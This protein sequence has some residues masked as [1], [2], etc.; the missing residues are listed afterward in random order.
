MP[1]DTHPCSVTIED[2][3]AIITKVGNYS[4]LEEDE[5]DHHTTGWILPRI[6]GN[7]H[8]EQIFIN[9][10]SKGKG[11]IVSDGSSKEGR[12]TSAF[13][14]LPNKNIHG[15]KKVPEEPQ[16]QISYRGELGGILASICYTN[17]ICTNHN[18]SEG[19]CAMYCDNKWALS[20]AF[21]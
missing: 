15:S 14:V 11:Q 12:S 21:G 9:N 20:A 5:E 19:L 13:V 3:N 6:S 10:I 16:D 2:N 7:N 17:K 1:E 18:I 8:E 4:E